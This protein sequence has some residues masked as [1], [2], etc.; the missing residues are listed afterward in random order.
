[1]L[2]G[3]NKTKNNN[4]EYATT[5][6]KERLSTD[7]LDHF[8]EAY[9]IDSKNT[10]NASIP[11]ILKN[12]QQIGIDLVKIDLNPTRTPREHFKY[13]F[14][15]TLP[16]HKAD[17]TFTLKDLMYIVDK[18]GKPIPWSNDKI[19]FVQFM[20]LADELGY[21]IVL[22]ELTK[23]PKNPVLST[24]IGAIKPIIHEDKE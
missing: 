18:T 16:F 8:A 19:A 7:A 23:D 15:Q 6:K 11:Y 9:A 21:L 24:P 13:L 22:D 2:F 4:T 14:G 5:F 12:G 3:K 17:D 1:M 10:N 20:K